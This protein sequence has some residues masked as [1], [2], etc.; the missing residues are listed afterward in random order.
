M[1]W[2]VP[3]ADGGSEEGE[4]QQSSDA[5]MSPSKV[6]D[7]SPRVFVHLFACCHEG[8]KASPTLPNEVK[9]GKLERSVAKEPL[10]GDE[11]VTEMS[12]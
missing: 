3:S 1:F 12:R 7:R 10:A 11:L 2:L 4:E 8:I 6:V 5:S 9:F